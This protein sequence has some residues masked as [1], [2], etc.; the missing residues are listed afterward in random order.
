[1][2]DRLREAGIRV[3]QRSVAVA[4]PTS[5]PTTAEGP[6]LVKSSSLVQCISAAKGVASP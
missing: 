1:M 3:V 4:S 2:R 6:I 5:H